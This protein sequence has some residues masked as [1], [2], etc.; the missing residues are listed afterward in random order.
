MK[1]LTDNFQQ[2]SYKLDILVC[3]SISIQMYVDTLYI[4]IH[5]H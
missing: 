4:Q 2:Q 1:P 3:L 5:L